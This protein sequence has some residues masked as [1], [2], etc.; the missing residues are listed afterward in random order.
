MIMV[1]SPTPIR[2]QTPA[3]IHMPHPAQFGGKRGPHRLPLA[4]RDPS[5]HSATAGRNLLMVQSGLHFARIIPRRDLLDLLHYGRD[6]VRRADPHGIVDYRGWRGGRAVRIVGAINPAG[7]VAGRGADVEP[8]VGRES[9]VEWLPV[10]PVGVALMVLL[11]LLLLVVRVR[12]SGPVRGG[13]RRLIMVGRG[14]P[15]APAVRAGG[16]ELGNV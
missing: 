9:G 3:A 13:A 16:V 7:V 2:R 6:A 8:V 12:I 1:I 14:A 15:A 4:A 11:L 10:L 5:P